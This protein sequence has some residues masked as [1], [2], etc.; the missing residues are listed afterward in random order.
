MM[1][2]SWLLH[3]TGVDEKGGSKIIKDNMQ[4]TLQVV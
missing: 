3:L 2:A 4:T 1:V